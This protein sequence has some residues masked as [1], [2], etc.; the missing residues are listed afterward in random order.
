MKSYVVTGASTGIGREIAMALAR[1]G[2]RVVMGR[3]EPPRAAA[4]LDLVKAKA[5]GQVSSL[6]ADLSLLAEARRVVKQ[7]R[8][9]LQRLDGLVLNAAVVTPKRTVTSEG[10]ETTLATNVLAPLVVTSELLPLLKA[11]A[12]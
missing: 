8:A 11:S 10:L 2:H 7:L 4:A 12:P 1:D 5:K 3:R 6:T 9:S